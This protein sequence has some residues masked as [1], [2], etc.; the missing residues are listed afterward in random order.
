VGRYSKMKYS[1]LIE[2]ADLNLDKNIL[3][4]RLLWVVLFVLLFV[5]LFLSLSKPFD[6]DE[7]E[8]IHASW[9]I[10][11]GQRIY[12]D[13]FEHHHPFFYYMLV[14]LIG[15]FKES[16][17]TVI[18]ARVLIIPMLLVIFVIT[19]NISKDLFGKEPALISLVLLATTNVFIWKAV[20]VRPDVPQTLF[21]L[22]SVSVLF[23]YFQKNSLKY[24]VLSAVSLGLSFLFLQK[25]LFLMLVLG[26]LLLWSGYTNQIKFRDIGVFAITFIAILMP[27]YVYLFFTDQLQAYWVYNW[28]MNSGVLQYASLSHGGDVMWKLISSFKDN[29]VLWIFWLLS[30]ALLDTPNQERL[31]AIS[32]FLLIIF[33]LAQVSYSQYLMLVMPLIAIMAG[34]AVH[35]LA[36]LFSDKKLF[37]TGLVVM[38]SIFYPLGSYFKAIKFYSNAAE[39]GKMEYVLSITKPKDLVYD[40]GSFFNLF[41]NDLD[42]FWFSTEDARV[43]SWIRGKTAYHYDVYELIDKLK[44]KVISQYHIG[45]MKDYRIAHHYRRSGK[46]RDLFIRIN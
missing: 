20:E 27:Y 9:K 38:M 14:P 6:P 43:F 40:G 28:T 30:L 21:G 5:I 12:V 25:A 15:I 18:A 45:N 24:L 37:I 10:F 3:Y 23:R 36:S 22:L 4:I 46:Y 13:F 2:G 26:V 42:F 17:I 31:G 39:L 29:P 35:R 32:L 44:P 34:Y 8:S 33:I 11:S 7:L 1:F 19:Y 41:R 16:V